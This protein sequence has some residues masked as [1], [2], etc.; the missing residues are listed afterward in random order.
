ME[1]LHFFNDSQTRKFRS[2]YTEKK[3]PSLR[4]ARFTI[5]SSE[6]IRKKRSSLRVHCIFGPTHFLGKT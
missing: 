3:N 1:A 5:D 2:A 6:G 4:A